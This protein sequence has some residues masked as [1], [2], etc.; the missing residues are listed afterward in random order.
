MRNITVKC[1]HCGFQKTFDEDE[2]EPSVLEGWAY[3][4][5]RGPYKDIEICP[6]CAKS[7][8]GVTELKEEKEND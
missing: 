5:V 6:E 7:F 3:I 1:D 2:F 4:N 8:F